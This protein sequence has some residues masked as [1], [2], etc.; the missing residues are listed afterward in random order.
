MKIWRYILPCICVLCC[1]TLPFAV[2]AENE[3]AG[4]D[5]SMLRAAIFVMNRAG[6][7]YQNKID[8]LNDLITA[9]LTEKG[10]SIIDKQVVVE[11][12]REA[13][14]EDVEVKKTIEALTNGT[15]DFSVEESMKDAS[16][17]R[18]AQMIGADYLVMATINS[19][20]HTTKKFKGG[21]T[22]YG[23]DNEVTDYTLRVALKILEAGQ[24]G[25]VYGDVV[26]V[27][28]RIPQTENLEIESSD[29]INNLL[30][31][32]AVEVADNIGGRVEEIRMAKVKHSGG[33]PFTI[34]TNGIDAVTVELDGAAIGSA[35]S[36]P[37][38]FVAP[39]GIHMMRITKQWFI[40]WEKPVNIYADQQLNVTLELS[41]VGI[42]RF[43]NLEGFKTEMAIAKE[44]SDA[45]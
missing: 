9:H 15:I 21:E 31:E 44:Q 18:L 40:P 23:V 32:A 37:V 35:S 34:V 3:E 5:Q 28:E 7:A 33:V 27:T 43:K 45:A 42:E 39:P 13:R 11:K 24:G 20:G 16:A 41:D 4:A 17:L 38:N 6:D 19:I 12:F 14:D 10:F 2:V 22:I 30:E 26:K 29:I 25:S 36:E 8:V 1:V